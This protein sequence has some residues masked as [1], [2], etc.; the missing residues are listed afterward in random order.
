MA[1]PLLKKG[2][3]G[4]AVR[5]LQWALEE[6]GYDPGDVGGV[7]GQGRNRRFRPSSVTAVRRG[8]HRRRDHVAD[9]R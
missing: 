5:Q 7:S 2:S 9:H 3:T 1:E 8:R 6:L 4:E